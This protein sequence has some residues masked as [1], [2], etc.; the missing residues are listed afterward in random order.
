MD[1]DSEKNLKRLYKLLGEE[2]AER[3]NNTILKN[4][5]GYGLN[6]I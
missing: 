2:D 4:S 5:I 6:I 1:G 3:L